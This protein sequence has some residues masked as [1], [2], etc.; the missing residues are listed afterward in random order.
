M[1]SENEKIITAMILEVMGRP[2][3]HLPEVL[4]DIIAKM[5]SEK[6][7][8]VVSNE[9]HEPVE[10]KDKK[11]LFTTFAEIEVHADDIFSL[12]VLMFK[13]MPSHIEI[14]NPEVLALTNNKWNQILNELATRL[15][16]Y[17]EVV[18]ILQVEKA[19]L[20]QQIRRLLPKG[21][22]ESEEK[23]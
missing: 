18:R 7:I 1:S 19:V 9:I 15:H 23:K 11:D 21:E 10:I 13:F 4:R 17:D 2:K 14:I 12:A 22:K 16:Q 3:E 6:G 8:K 20:E 5:D